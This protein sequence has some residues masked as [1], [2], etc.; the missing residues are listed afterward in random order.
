MILAKYRS[1]P[2]DRHKEKRDPLGTGSIVA[3]QMYG[4]DNTAR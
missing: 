3:G 1:R 2:A 4:L